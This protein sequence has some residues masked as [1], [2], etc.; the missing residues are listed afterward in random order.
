MLTTVEG[1]FEDGIIKLAEQPAAV[2]PGA[3]V[4]VTFLSAPGVGLRERRIDPEEARELRA[5]LSAFAEDWESPE[6]AAY[7]DYHTAKSQR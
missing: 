2:Q 7:D 4:I 6:M 5:R 3:P 1:V